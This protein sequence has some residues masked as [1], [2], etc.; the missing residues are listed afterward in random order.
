V[1]LSPHSHSQPLCRSCSLLSTNVSL[2]GWL[3][4]PLPL[5]AF[6]ALPLL[7]HWESSA[8]IF[9][10]CPT[11][12]FQSSFRAPPPLLLSVLDY[13]LL[14]MFFSFSGRVQFAQGLTG[15]FS[16]GV[17]RG[18]AHCTW[19][20][21]VHSVVSCKHLWSQLAGRNGATFFQCGMVRE[22]FNGLGVQ[23]VTEFDSDWCSDFCLLVGKT[24]RQREKRETARWLFSPGLD[25]FCW[26]CHAG[27]LWLVGAIK[28]WC[29]GQS[30]N[31]ICT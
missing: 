6:A 2:G 31:F 16:W 12:V 22:A 24:E 17:G 11:P 8:E 30:L 5:P 3:V 7:F 27:I 19:Y 28:G 1:G 9:A 26:L 14:F 29:K 15:L 4:T 20:P 13:S 23:D 25:T 10:P 21:C 18:V